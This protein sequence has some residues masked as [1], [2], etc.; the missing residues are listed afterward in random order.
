[1]SPQEVRNC[2]LVM[3]NKSFFEWLR[4]L[5]KFDPFVLTTALSDRP[6]EEAY[7]TELALR[8]ILLANISE[9]DIKAVGDVGAFLTDRVS[10]IA[11]DKKFRKG[12]VKQLFEDTFTI[13]AETLDEQ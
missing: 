12:E 3:I 4:D 13:I 1:L 5:P 8:F 11:Q 7:D 2:L 6:I 10:A 9:Q